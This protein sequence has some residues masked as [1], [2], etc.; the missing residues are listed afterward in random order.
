M[1][2][3]MEFGWEGGQDPASL[4][5]KLEV[6]ESALDRRLFEAMEELGLRIESSAK[7]LV[8]VDHGRLRG[9]IS[10]EVRREGR[11]TIA[12]YVGTNVHYGPHIEYGRGAI[13]ASGDG[14]L[15]FEI[16]GEEIFVKSVGPADAQPYLRP[17][18]QKH[19][20][21]AE[22]LIEEAV[23]DAARDAGLS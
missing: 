15:H 8:A 16:E 22:D 21:T 10:S 20:G 9:S 17:A 2:G 1:A 5:S 13:T 6:F 11:S 12:L 3:D 18:I 23:E 4:T 7:R 19:R 14:V